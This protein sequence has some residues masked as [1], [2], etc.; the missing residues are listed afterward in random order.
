M[1]QS[2]L[3]PCIHLVAVTPL[4]AAAL[5]KSSDVSRKNTVLFYI[6]YL[7]YSLLLTLPMWVSAI[8]I[9]ESPFQW[10]WSG[11]IFAITAS[12]LFFMAYRHTFSKH[13]YIHF[14]WKTSTAKNLFLIGLAAFLVLIGLKLSAFMQSAERLEYFL[15]QLT[16]PGLDEELA[17][18]GIMLGLLGS[19]L[20]P[21]LKMGTFH[22]KNPA[23][24]LTA[25]LFGLSH[26]F[27]INSNWEWHQNWFNW[28]STFSVGW[29][30]GWVTLKSG[31]ILLAILIHIMINLL[32]KMIFWT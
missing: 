5:N 23:L 8:R 27:S 2:I 17:F 26:S 22:L 29:L 18:R 19:V 12:L 1:I 13:H 31:N 28:I 15:F 16:M 25:I 10:N 21:V 24:I 32:P 20:Q 3:I 6:Y 30:L 11:K 14:N 7:V 9:V 4:L